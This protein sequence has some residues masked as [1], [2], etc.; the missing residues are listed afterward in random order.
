MKL[1]VFLFTCLG[2]ITFSCTSFATLIS[3]QMENGKWK[4]ETSPFQCKLSQDIYGFGTVAFVK[5]PQSSLA[6]VF[7]PDKNTKVTSL[8]V[9][10]VASELKLSEQPPSKGFVEGRYDEHG[11][12]T[13]DNATTEFIEAVNVGDRLFVKSRFGSETE[14][15]VFTTL[16][17][18]RSV[19]LFYQCMDDMSPLTWSAARFS[20]LMFENNHTQLS[21]PQKQRLGELMRYLP[22]DN[23]VT[24]IM[25]DGHSDDAGSNLANR[26]LSQERADEVAAHLI[27]SGLDRNLL[28]VRAHGNRYPRKEN[29]QLSSNRRV[30]IR[31][32]KKVD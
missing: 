1:V 11:N 18:H 19:A 14:I 9:A 27:E 3:N 21:P 30:T 29:N 23:T 2:A 4:M 28:E 17:G 12:F 15:A 13:F 10:R 26:M 6:F 5:E 20:E 16:F 7:S 25:V 8:F 32:V 24:K 22:F 31:L